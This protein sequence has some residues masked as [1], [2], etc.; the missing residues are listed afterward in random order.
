M[1]DIG[2]KALSSAQYYLDK[3]TGLAPNKPV[4]KRTKLELL[5]DRNHA[6]C[7]AICFFI[8][9]SGSF[10]EDIQNKASDMIRNA[11]AAYLDEIPLAE[12]TA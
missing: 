2:S 4:I 9:E 12:D 8:L 11:N 1:E 6:S 3:L 10:N 7:V 5:I